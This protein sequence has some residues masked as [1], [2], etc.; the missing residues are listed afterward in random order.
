MRQLFK[1]QRLSEGT[2]S[3]LNL[4]CVS[5]LYS[6]ILFTLRSVVYL[7][8]VSSKFEKLFTS[9]TFH[10]ADN[11][12]QTK[13]SRWL[14]ILILCHYPAVSIKW[15]YNYS[16]HTHTHTHTHTNAWQLST[17]CQVIVYLTDTVDLTVRRLHRLPR[18]ITILLDTGEWK[19]AEIL[20]ESISGA[21][22]VGGVVEWCLD[23]YWPR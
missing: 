21:E 20:P 15:W 1:V 11:Y 9:S 3:S 2:G 6:T 18:V 7:P 16:T 8:N 22:T 19:Q 23:E 5:L 14:H 10:Y 4:Q 13:Q 12:T 17:F